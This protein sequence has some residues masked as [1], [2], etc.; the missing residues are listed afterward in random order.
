MTNPQDKEIFLT[1]GTFEKLGQAD[2][3]AII[4]YYRHEHVFSD[5]K[6]VD[7]PTSCCFTGKS[8]Y[9][10]SICACRKDTVSHA[11]S[12]DAHMYLQSASKAAS[13]TEDGYIDYI[14]GITD[15][16]KNT[17]KDQYG[18]HTHREIIPAT[19]HSYIESTDSSGTPC[20][21]CEHCGDVIYNAPASSEPPAS[22]ELPTDTESQAP[23]SSE[24]VS[25]AEQPSSENAPSDS[26]EQTGVASE[27]PPVNTTL[28]I[29]LIASAVTITAVFIV[30]MK[31]LST[32]K[33]KRR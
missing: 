1:D 16:L 14:C 17:G 4:E 7:Y 29:V 12:A 13:C 9:R 33:K 21:I 18:Y 2:A 30:V 24:Y 32:P 27:A 20:Y 5:S 31:S 28:I 10:C 26:T 8:S 3:D 15:L 25:S 22:S 23:A 11:A 19:G 6:E